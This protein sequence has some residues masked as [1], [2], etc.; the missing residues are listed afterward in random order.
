MHFEIGFHS[1]RFFSVTKTVPLFVPKDAPDKSLRVSSVEIR[2][3]PFYWM[4]PSSLNDLEPFLCSLQ[5]TL[6]FRLA[7]LPK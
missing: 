2:S 1:S 7:L 6:S 4:S 5:V 3:E